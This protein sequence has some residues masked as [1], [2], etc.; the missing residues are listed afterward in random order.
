MSGSLIFGI[1]DEP[2]SMYQEAG[3]TAAELGLDSAMFNILTPMPGT[4]TFASMF[5]DGRIT[6]FDWGLYDATHCVI[7]PLGTTPR[8]LEQL[9]VDAY[10]T[11]LA[12]VP[13]SYHDQAREMVHRDLDQLVARHGPDDEPAWVSYTAD[14]A[15]LADLVTVSAADANLAITTAVELAA[16]R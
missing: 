3:F 1:A 6:S 8:R 5:R 12:E 7:E 11:F 4:E 14:P 10:R 2:E 15:D 13:T 16:S 9:R